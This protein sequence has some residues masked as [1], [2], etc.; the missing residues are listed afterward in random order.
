[1]TVPPEDREKRIIVRVDPEIGD[2]VPGF[3]ENRNRDVELLRNALAQ[4]DYETVQITGH[5]MKGSGRA[6]GFDA[7]TDIG[8]NIEEAAKNKDSEEVERWIG[9]LKEY[10]GRVEVVYE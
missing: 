6:Y 9:A 3:L 5:S 2:L 4:G 1:M 7:I 8:R 10:L